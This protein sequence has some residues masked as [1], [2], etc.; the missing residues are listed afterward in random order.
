[1]SGVFNIVDSLR[2]GGHVAPIVQARTELY[3][4]FAR[5]H[6]RAA[7]ADECDRLDT[8]LDGLLM[9]KLG[10][11][12]PV[13]EA[14]TWFNINFLFDGEQ[15]TAITLAEYG[16]DTAV[17]SQYKPQIP[18]DSG[19]SEDVVDRWVSRAYRLAMGNRTDDDIMWMAKRYKG[20]PRPR[21]NAMDI[22]SGHT[23][24][25]DYADVVT[26]LPSHPPADVDMRR[27]MHNIHFNDINPTVDRP[28]PLSYASANI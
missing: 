27:G 18:H 17:A 11:E 1:M 5:R 19:A 25:I 8:A 9:P 14:E 26:D 21:G 2:G 4:L 6:G 12:H 3:A 13:D 10:F 22:A 23:H 24:T 16:I 15:A 7:I 20:E 28:D